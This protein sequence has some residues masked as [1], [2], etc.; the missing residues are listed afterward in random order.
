MH[1]RNLTVY[2]FADTRILVYGNLVM[3]LCVQGCRSMCP[4]FVRPYHLIFGSASE[5][6]QFV[7]FICATN[8]SSFSTTYFEELTLGPNRFRPYSVSN[9]DT[10]ACMNYLIDIVC[11]DHSGN[12]DIANNLGLSEQ[13]VVR[14]G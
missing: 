3:M 6:V 14:W 10:Q 11:D 7:K 12:L 4:P 13:C 2:R 8:V 5:L 9:Y 1:L